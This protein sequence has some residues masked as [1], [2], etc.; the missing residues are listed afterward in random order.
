MERQASFVIIDPDKPR[1]F[2]SHDSYFTELH[3]FRFVDRQDD[4]DQPERFNSS[5]NT[6]MHSVEDQLGDDEEWQILPE[7]VNI[8]SIPVFDDEFSYAV[9][10]QTVSNEIVHVPF[11]MASRFMK[12]THAIAQSIG[13]ISLQTL[14]D[15]KQVVYTAYIN[16]EDNINDIVNGTTNKLKRCFSKSVVISQQVLGYIKKTTKS[17]Q[18]Q[19]HDLAIKARNKIFKVSWFFTTRALLHGSQALKRLTLLSCEGVYYL[20]EP[21][22]EIIIQQM[23]KLDD[24]IMAIGGYTTRQINHI[25]SYPLIQ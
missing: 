25:C 9:C 19:M 13:I 14:D 4:D 21:I 10:F 1:R 15:T 5:P 3:K 20:Y 2:S 24:K 6:L 8:A 22:G 17:Y 18:P 16:N 11:H 23:Q 7:W 12:D